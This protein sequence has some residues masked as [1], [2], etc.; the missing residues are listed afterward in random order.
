MEPTTVYQTASTPT[1]APPSSG[2]RLIVSHVDDGFIAR[3]CRHFQEMG[4]DVYPAD[5]AEEVRRRAAGS[6]ASVVILPTEYPNES[7]WLTCAKLVREHPQHR[8]ILVGSYTTPTLQRYTSFV[9][10]TAL[11]GLDSSMRSLVAEVYA[12]AHIPLMN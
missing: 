6:P 1:L 4:W 5:S 8:V 3:V 10:G 12:A 7:G 2:S 9:G 11:L